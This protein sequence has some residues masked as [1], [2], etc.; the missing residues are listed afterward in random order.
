MRSNEAPH[1][2]TTA[3]IGTDRLHCN[4]CS[5]PQRVY[6][7]DGQ[8]VD[9]TPGDVTAVVT[10]VS[11]SIGAGAAKPLA[12]EGASVVMNYATR[13][14]DADR[15]VADIASKGGKAFAIQGD[16]QMMSH[17]CRRSSTSDLMAGASSTSVRPSL[18][19]KRS[20]TD[21][22]HG[23]CPRS[24]TA[25]TI[26]DSRYLGASGPDRTRRSTTDQQVEKDCGGAASFSRRQIVRDSD[27]FVV[28]KRD[29][30]S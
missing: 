19:T 14:R 4:S 30:D 27:Q 28:T 2:T 9:M 13:R 21:V 16:V 18:A 12:T 15:V 23:V 3:R 5:V 29:R 26:F 7:V 20:A 10:C 25:P 22:R 24:T 1:L 8:R 17:I 11:K 6:T